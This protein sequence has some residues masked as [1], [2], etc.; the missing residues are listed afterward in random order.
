MVVSVLGQSCCLQGITP[1]VIYLVEGEKFSKLIG[2][3]HKGLVLQLIEPAQ[4]MFLQ[5]LDE[6]LI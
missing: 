6:P 5:Y 3:N 4:I 1:T 2:K